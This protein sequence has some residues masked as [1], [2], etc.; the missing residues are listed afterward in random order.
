MTTELN[1]I[2]SFTDRKLAEAHAKKIS[3]MTEGLHETTMIIYLPFLYDAEEK[4]LPIHNEIKEKLV[5]MAVVDK[6]KI[7]VPIDENLLDL[8]CNLKV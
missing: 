4:V 8:V 5:E 3:N 2:N 1:F 7:Q 6:T